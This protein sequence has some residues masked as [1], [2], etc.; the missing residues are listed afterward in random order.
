M[1]VSFR[2]I[3]L[4]LCGLTVLLLAGALLSLVTRT[5]PHDLWASLR[6]EEIQ[7][8]IKL[9]L[10]TS[11]SSTALCV[12]VAVPTA[13]VLTHK[14]FWGRSIINVILQLPLA[15]PPVVAGMALLVLF[16]ATDFGRGLADLGIR[17]VF[18]TQG[19][20]LAQF[21]VIVPFMYRIM[22]TT[23]QGIN[24]RYEHVAQ[25]LGCSDFE[26]FRRVTMPMAR[27]GLIAG[28]IIAWCRALGEFGA[29]LML[30]GATRMRTETLPTALYLN[31]T[32][33]NLPLA[34]AAATILIGI[35]FVA[36]I[37]FERAAGTSRVF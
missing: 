23:F 30:A 9:S 4:T 15:L 3:A 22:K 28:A 5:T 1:D 24:P 12:V 32:S 8:A 33:G 6:S 17:F 13:Y 2:S 31:M 7:F 18:T 14:R 11:L 21:F 34:V 20:I 29:A 16:G 25:T 10:L 27:N 26:V 37:I 36:L 35:A 19:I